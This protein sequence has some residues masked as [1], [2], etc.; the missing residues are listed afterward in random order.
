MKEL[1]KDGESFC[2]TGLATD[3]EGRNESI[4]III[5]PDDV[6]ENCKK[7]ENLDRLNPLIYNHSLL[8]EEASK[9]QRKYD[10]DG[11]AFT[12]GSQRMGKELFTDKK[13]I[14]KTNFGYG[15][16]KEITAI[17]RS[18]MVE[19]FKNT[20]IFLI[21]PPT[22]TGI[23]LQDKPGL[24]FSVSD[25]TLTAYSTIGHVDV[26]G[27]KTSNLSSQSNATPERKFAVILPTDNIFAKTS[28]VKNISP[29]IHMISPDN[30]L[31]T[32]KNFFSN[33]EINLSESASAASGLNFSG[34][35]T[36][37]DVISSDQALVLENSSVSTEESFGNDAISFK[38]PALLE[39]T[40]DV[41]AV[42]IEQKTLAKASA[43]YDIS[44]LNGASTFSMVATQ[45]VDKLVGSTGFLGNDE[46]TT[47]VNGVGRNIPING[48]LLQPISS[49][50]FPG[51]S[52]IPVEPFLTDAN[53]NSKSIEILSNMA[54]R[55]RGTKS[56]WGI[57]CDLSKTA[58]NSS[59]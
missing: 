13:K 35:S 30:T 25:T 4:L 17:N 49:V 51:S 29:S 46:S 5:S 8:N 28:V 14:E 26:N 34:L 12:N 36:W 11:G 19:S 37:P 24:N 15:P 43:S 42:E 27:P 1:P 47:I 10:R 45:S 50:T 23:D 40:S 31:P 18:G 22:F 9:I 52:K 59:S 39:S 2:L 33:K 56:I 58:K 20:T 7:Y 21:A 55:L 16:S 41:T 54:C 6:A 57:I 32:L 38:K 53:H 44:L 48:N 3:D